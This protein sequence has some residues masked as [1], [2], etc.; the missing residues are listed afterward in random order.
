MF[1]RKSLPYNHK[2]KIVIEMGHPMRNY[3]GAYMH[4]YRWI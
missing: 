2:F 1:P 3:I 4:I